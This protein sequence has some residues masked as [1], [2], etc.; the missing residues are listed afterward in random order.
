MKN[1][2]D[3]HAVVQGQGGFLGLFGRSTG[4]TGGL[5]IV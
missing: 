2:D 4:A 3:M 1:I 5:N